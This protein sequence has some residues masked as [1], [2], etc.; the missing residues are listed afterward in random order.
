MH[1][2]A[3]ELRKYLMKGPHNSSNQVLSGSIWKSDKQFKCHGT[4]CHHVCVLGIADLGNMRVYSS[5]HTVSF[6]TK[7][8]HE[9]DHV[10]MDCAERNLVSPNQLEYERRIALYFEQKANLHYHVHR[11]DT[12][13]S[14]VQ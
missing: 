12:V 4:M 8:L 3:L 14:S 13:A 9:Q 6:M 5:M 2:K 11:R 7:C 10:V 1:E